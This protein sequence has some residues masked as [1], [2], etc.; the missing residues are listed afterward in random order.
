MKNTI[1]AIVLLLSTLGYAQNDEPYVDSLVLEFTTNLESR[2]INTYLVSKRYCLGEINIFKLGNGKMCTSK[3]TY[4]AVYVF[5]QEEGKNMTKKIDNCG[6][7]LSVEL[8]DD[9]VLDFMNRNEENIRLNPVKPYEIAAKESG[10]IK[11]T[12]TY[13][14]SRIIKY[15]RGGSVLDQSFDLFDLTNDA[16][17]DNINYDYNNGLHAVELDKILTLVISQVDNKFYRQ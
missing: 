6:L 8:E 14:C 12:E 15:V 5:W 3:F 1:I 10:P 11:S 9:M 13:P 16:L 17:E 7:Y 4:F 2:N